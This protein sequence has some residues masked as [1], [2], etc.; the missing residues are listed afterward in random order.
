L[1]SYTRTAKATRRIK[2]DRNKNVETDLAFWSKFLGEG[3]ETMNIGDLHVTDLLIDTKFLT[4][5]VPDAS[6]V[7]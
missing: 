2:F 3:N 1:P 7:A 5:E 6:E 4:V